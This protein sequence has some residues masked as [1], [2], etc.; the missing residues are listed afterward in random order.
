[1]ENFK[2]KIELVYKKIYSQNINQL[3]K[4][5]LP[6]LNPTKTQ[7]RSRKITINKWL[8]GEIT[9]PYH[10]QS[11]Y[12]KYPISKKITEKG[13]PLLPLEAFSRSLE[14]FEKRLNDYENNQPSKET[15]LNEYQYIYIYSEDKNKLVYIKITYL[16]NDQVEMVA[17]NY[18][19]QRVY[20]GRVELHRDS[21]ILH[22][23][24][25]S[26]FEKIFFSFSNLQIKLN[27]RCYG[28]QL[29]KSLL[30]EVPMSS[31][32]LLSKKIL[33]EEE[34][35]FFITRMN[36]SNN[37]FAQNMKESKEESFI[38]NISSKLDG[39]NQIINDYD[40]HNN[41]FLDFLLKE[42]NIFHK[43]LNNALTKH[44]F[45]SYLNV[46]QLLKNILSSQKLLKT[47]LIIKVF[48]TITNEDKFIF[49]L[50]EI[51]LYNL[52]VDLHKE[53]KLYIELTLYINNEVKLI[54]QIQ[55]KLKSFKELNIPLYFTKNSQTNYSSIIVVQNYS[56]GMF[57][58][59]NEKEY[60]IT[61][62][63][64]TLNGKYKIEKSSSLLNLTE[65]L[66]Q[67]NKLLQGRWYLY[68]YGR[69]LHKAEI[70]IDAYSVKIN[71]IEPDR[72]EYFGTVSKKY[73]NIEISTNFGLIR[74]REYEQSSIKIVAFISGQRDADDKHVITFAIFSRWNL[75]EEDLNSIFPKLVNK[76][77]SPYEQA[78]FKLSLGLDD[79]LRELVNKYEQINPLLG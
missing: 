40:N 4:A 72:R 50:T 36:S 62:D 35:S 42:F 17:N 25:S 63:L 14:E 74:F 73:E 47:E 54:E 21:G 9:T 49:D 77:F 13:E 79:K 5:F 7:I 15:P 57:L 18:N 70:N 2:K 39:L 43:K 22:Y 12:N 66:N 78:S 27:T 41:L 34:K 55:D 64:D 61:H 65:L 33:T 26:E 45:S 29:S 23:L 24:V 19:I 67:N 44:Q 10:F 3:T 11:D 53:K 30:K 76:E 58:L 38:D 51:E 59:K 20:R 1:M 16:E 48:Y 52:I 68:V 6:V 46:N 32:V 56:M 37:L 60:K 69:V 75:K 28:L 8:K 31:L 71:L